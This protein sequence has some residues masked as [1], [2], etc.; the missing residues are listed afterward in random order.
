MIPDH[1]CNYKYKENSSFFF[2]TSLVSHP[3]LNILYNESKVC[4]KYCSLQKRNQYSGTYATD[5]QKDTIFPRQ[6]SPQ[7]LLS[8]ASGSQNRTS[9]FR[10]LSLQVT[11]DRFKSTRIWG[12]FPLKANSET[13]LGFQIHPLS[14]TNGNVCISEAPLDPFAHS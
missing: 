12:G 6:V 11:V 10:E 4:V 7:A 2:F 13:P 5:M 1:R 14:I 8:S 9:A 3:I